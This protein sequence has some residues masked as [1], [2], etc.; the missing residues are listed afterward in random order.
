MFKIVTLSLLVTAAP[1]QSLTGFWMLPKQEVQVVMAEGDGGKLD[2]V[3][4]TSLKCKKK[5]YTPF[6]GKVHHKGEE[7]AFSANSKVMPLT[8]KCTVEFTFMGYGRVKAG[9][10]REFHVKAAMV[11]FVKC[12]NNNNKMEIDDLSGTWLHFLKQK[13]KGVSI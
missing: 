13:G 8:K 10:P 1:E 6:T 7:I 4:I 11:S 2:M 5:V 3:T 9:N 12:S